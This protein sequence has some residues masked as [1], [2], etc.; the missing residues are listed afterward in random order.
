M[1]KINSKLLTISEIESSVLYGKA[2]I[3]ETN[4]T[5]K[6]ELHVNGKL[7]KSLIVN[8]TDSEPSDLNPTSFEFELTDLEVWLTNEIEIRVESDD[9]DVLASASVQYCPKIEE[10]SDQLRNIF[11]TGYY[12]SRFMHSLPNTEIAFEHY[13]TRGIY[14][15]ANPNIW[16]SNRYFREHY[17]DLIGKR[18]IPILVYLD[19]ESQRKYSA[20]EI[21]SPKHY[22]EANPDL[23]GI[24]ALLAH[25]VQHGHNEGRNCSQVELQEELISEV[26]NLIEIEPLIEPIESNR[27]RIV[28]YPFLKQSIFAP[29]IAKKYFGSEIKAIV[30]TPFISVG[31]A[32][33]VSTYVLKALQKKYSE[34]NVI[35][36]VTDQ[37]RI[38][39][40][41]WISSGSE[42]I[43]L[44]QLCGD[45]SSA[46]ARMDTL[47]HVIGE[48]N[49][50]LIF[51]VNSHVAWDLYRKFGKQLSSAI[52]LYAYLFCFDFN[53][54]NKRV[55]YIPA[56][57]P[58]CIGYLKKV[59]FDNKQILD[60]LRTLYGFSSSNLE[61]LQTLYIPS[62]DLDSISTIH[63]S[64]PESERGKRKVLWAGRFAKQKRVDIL[65]R[66]SQAMPDVQFDVYGTEGNAEEG[67]GIVENNY[68][69]I[70]YKGTFSSYNDL[71]IH[72]YDAYLYT[73]QWDGIPSILINM[74][75]MGVPICAPEVGGIP[76]LVFKDTGWPVK[77]YDDVQE[78]ETTLRRIF[79]SREI[80]KQKSRLGIKHVKARHQWDLFNETI[81]TALGEKVQISDIAIASNA[82]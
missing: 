45:G 5:L 26:G 64:L 71:A 69:N 57:L 25:Y 70:N 6:I 41:D 48:L 7:T 50:E 61:R 24:H 54:H 34:S 10:F 40:P 15:D 36:I 55:G 31:G 9:N 35:F 77:K 18:A 58:T 13:L 51:N 65:I 28:K 33:L 16:F 76:E 38:E 75:R 21:F 46:N 78:F 63:R 39:R 79:S 60:E 27:T 66:I 74:M 42:I 43:D 62:E 12:V 14:Q 4:P 81:A 73:S 17:C 1:K 2:E 59:F 22:V 47:Y 30:C 49:P 56:Y 37:S 20:S 53:Q 11:D 68:A 52:D 29:S 19:R 82:R 32:D 8:S 23:A 80:G 72:E 44:P 3:S 67:R